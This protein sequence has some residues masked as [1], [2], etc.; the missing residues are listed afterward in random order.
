M[1][2]EGVRRRLGATTRAIGKTRGRVDVERERERE[3]DVA[4]GARA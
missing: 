3:R 1:A 2:R 4:E